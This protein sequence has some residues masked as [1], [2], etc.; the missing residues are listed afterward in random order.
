[1]IEILK[2]QAFY[3][4]FS[5]ANSWPQPDIKLFI[6]CAVLLL[7]LIGIVLYTHKVFL[8]SISLFFVLSMYTQNVVQ[9]LLY[10]SYDVV[11]LTNII[12]TL[13][14]IPVCSI[15]II[16][17]P[18]TCKL[19]RDVIFEAFM[20]DQLST[21]FSSIE[22]LWLVSV[23]K[24]D[25]HTWMATCETCNDDDLPAAAVEVISKLSCTRPCP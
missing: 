7:L 22:K 6:T 10:Y 23:G 2:Q 1:M 11:Y 9:Y 25:K 17:I 8:I 16:N 21:K 4:L 12:Q 18:Y 13:I 15:S 14:I 24:K 5:I 19:L 3:R 20:V